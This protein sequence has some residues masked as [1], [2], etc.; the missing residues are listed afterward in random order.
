MRAVEKFNYEKR[1]PFQHLCYLVDPPVHYKGDSRSGKDYP[2]P[3]AYGRSHQPGDAKFQKDASGTGTGTYYS[4][5]CRTLTYD[6][7]KVE[8]VLNM[9][10]EPVSLETPV[11]EEEDSHLVDFIQDEKMSF[12]RMRLLLC[13]YMSS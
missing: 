13:F 5:N 6:Q 8:E 2:H 4:G 9:A 10:Q 3:G 12:C 11:G 1:L 7:Q